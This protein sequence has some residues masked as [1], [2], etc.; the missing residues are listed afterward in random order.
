MIVLEVDLVEGHELELVTV[1]PSRLHQFVYCPRQVFFD[2]YV[3]APKPLG[4]RLR[5]LLGR[6]LH[7]LR[8][9]IRLRWVR[10]RVLEVELPELGVRLVGKP[11][12]FKVDGGTVTVEEFKS[13]RKPRKPNRW[14]FHCWESDMVQAL[15]YGVILKR[16]TGLN[17]RVVVKYLD[18]EVEVPFNPAPLIYY[19]ELYKTMVECSLLPEVDLNSR[20][21]RCQYRELCLQLED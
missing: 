21:R 6:L 13:G 3:K 20:C 15:A 17:P 9:L 14:G 11:D 7:L 5:M 10:E 18:G 16:L 8:G 2:H 19:L 4:Q 12:C 1:T